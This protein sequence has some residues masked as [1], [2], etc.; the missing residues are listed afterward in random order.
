[1]NKIIFFPQ[2]E[3]HIDNM[4][5]IANELKDKYNIIF[6][7]AAKYF[8]QDIY[9][10]NFPFEILD[11]QGGG[12]TPFYLES[13][14]GKLK[15]VWEFKKNLKS[16]DLSTKISAVVVANDGAMQRVLLKNLSKAKSILILDGIISDYSFSFTD[17]FKLSKDKASDLKDYF[18]RA[19][20]V[21]VARFIARLPFNEFI[22][23]EIGSSNFDIAFTLSDYV[24]DVLKERHSPI[25]RFYSYG[26]PRYSSMLNV[27]PY[28]IK[29]NKIL[30]VSQGYLWHNEIANDESQHAEIK[31]LLLMLKQRDLSGKYEVV[32]RVHPRDDISR[33][34]KYNVQL[35]SSNYDINTSILE[36]SIVFGFNSTVLLESAWYGRPTCSLLTQGQAWKF[37]RSFLGVGVV[38]VITKKSQLDSIL[39]QL[40]S[41][42]LVVGSNASS[43]FNPIQENTQAM[44]CN[45]I[46]EVVNER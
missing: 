22:P 40:C 33:Y 20:R 31:Q 38:G 11:V 9:C 4:L 2:N 7:S 5:P 3:T 42:G 36:S 26:L 12:V 28:G 35:E 34:E 45:K 32:I 21:A 14:L 18:R 10:E 44:I 37:K 1:M 15:R 13:S 6:I 16:I 43:V 29:D 39:A 23:S 8:K 25:K 46:Q 17:I 27:K 30:I 19:L 41:G 24:S